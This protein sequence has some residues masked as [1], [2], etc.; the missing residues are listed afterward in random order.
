MRSGAAVGHRGYFHQTAFYA[1]DEEFLAVAQPFLSEGLNAGEPVVVAS[2]PHHQRLIK[3]VFPG[4]SE[5]RYIENGAQYVGPAAA[6]SAYRRLL[7]DYV[8]QGAQQI[9]VT[10]DVPHPG[11]GVPWDWW[12]RYESAVNVAF[13]DFPLWGL[14]P[15]DTRI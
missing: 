3:D 1:T 5:I 12:A 10:G 13:D 4:V 11:L 14:C 2:T 6:I 7:A 8:R 15:Y 9:R